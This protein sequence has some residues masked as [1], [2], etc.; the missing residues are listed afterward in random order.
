MWRLEKGAFF[1]KNEVVK[2]IRLDPGWLTADA[3]RYGKS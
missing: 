3:F 1:A 2:G